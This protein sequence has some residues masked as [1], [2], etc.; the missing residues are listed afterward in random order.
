MARQYAIA[1]AGGK[2]KQNY[3]RWPTVDLN[4][5]KGPPYPNST[6]LVSKPLLNGSM[7]HIPESSS[8]QDVMETCIRLREPDVTLPSGPQAG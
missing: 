6:K 8:G 3:S 4:I 7:A 5:L 1:V 2:N